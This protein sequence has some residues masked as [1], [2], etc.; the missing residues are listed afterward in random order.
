MIDDLGLSGYQYSWVGSI[1]Y[2]GVSPYPNPAKK[3]LR[4]G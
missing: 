2:F 4:K 1:M 3:E